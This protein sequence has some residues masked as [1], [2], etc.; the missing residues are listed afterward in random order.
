MLLVWRSSS[1]NQGASCT[2]VGN[3]RAACVRI[4]PKERAHCPRRNFSVMESC[5]RA[6]KTTPKGSPGLTGKTAACC[7]DSKVQCMVKHN[8]RHVC[9]TMHCPLLSM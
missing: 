8:A 1:D 9:F 7:M 2:C 5:P 4:A 6:S 3:A